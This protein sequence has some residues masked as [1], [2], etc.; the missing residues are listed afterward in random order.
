MFLTTTTWVWF[1]LVNE[2]NK[3]GPFKAQPGETIEC[4]FFR[5]MSAKIG[6]QK[7]KRKR[8][9]YGS[10]SYTYSNYPMSKFTFTAGQPGDKRHP[11]TL[12]RFAEPLQNMSVGYGERLFYVRR[13]P[14]EHYKRKTYPMKPK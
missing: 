1:Q 10:H 3:R 6:G 9:A 8:C 5:A 7:R 11:L 2:R 4:V 14:T 13:E 12:A